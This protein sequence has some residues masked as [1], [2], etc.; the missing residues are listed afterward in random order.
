MPP[1]C[2]GCPAILELVPLSRESKT[3]DV[4]CS[5]PAPP[6]KKVKG[7]PQ[8]GHSTFASPLVGEALARAHCR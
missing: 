6:T 7:R 2:H 5:S 1:R 8:G 3:T 4:A